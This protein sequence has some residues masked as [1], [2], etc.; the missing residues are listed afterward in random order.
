M[1]NRILVPVDGSEHALHAVASAEGLLRQIPGNRGSLTLLYVSPTIMLNEAALG[2]NL[3]ELQQ[4][5]GRRILEGAVLRLSE[6]EVEH[7]TKYCSG[8]P[9]QTICEVAR[10]GKY[11]LIVMGS[12]GLS[13]FSEL[14]IGSVSHKVIQ[15][16]SCPVMIVK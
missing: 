6:S 13:A 7:E 1:Y 2:V 14:F 3:V 12:R 8:D 15:H 11:D 10:E 9:A 5:E 16:A 4:E